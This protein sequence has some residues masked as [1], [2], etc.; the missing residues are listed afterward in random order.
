MQ[1]NLTFDAK[2]C[3]VCVPFFFASN[4]ET[5]SFIRLC[6]AIKL[7]GEVAHK[8]C[9]AYC[10]SWCGESAMYSV[11]CLNGYITILVTNSDGYSS[12]T[13]YKITEAIQEAF[14]EAKK[15]LG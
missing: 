15:K 12:K 1:L 9:K 14:A 11:D 6:D 8:N 4:E 5:K 3:T 10:H 2:G 13:T 7:W